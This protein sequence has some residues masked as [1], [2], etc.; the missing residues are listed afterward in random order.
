MRQSEN[1]KRHLPRLS[2][3]A[4]P[5][6]YKVSEA[7]SSSSI[8]SSTRASIATS[9]EESLST[10]PFFVTCLYDFEAGAE[11]QLSFKKG[12]VLE[13]VKK[14]DT[15]RHLVIYMSIHHVNVS[16][17]RAGGPLSVNTITPWAGYPVPM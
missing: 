13:I 9:Y 15:V 6:T 14:E 2:I 11:E 12:E 1:A 4:S 17:C 5:Y 8:I 7:P 3:N 16:P 10:G